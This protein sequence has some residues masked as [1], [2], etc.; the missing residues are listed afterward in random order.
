M[1]SARASVSTADSIPHR[2]EVEPATRAGQSVRYHANLPAEFNEIRPNQGSRCRT[3]SFRSPETTTSSFETSIHTEAARGGLS[4]RK[5]PK[6]SG[7]AGASHTPCVGTQGIKAK[8]SPDEITRVRIRHGL[9]VFAAV[10]S[11]EQLRQAVVKEGGRFQQ[12][13]C[14]LLRFLHEAIPQEPCGD[15]GVVVRPHQTVATARRS[16][17]LQALSARI[18][19]QEEHDHSDDQDDD[20]DPEQKLEGRDETTGE[21]QYDG[22]DGDNDE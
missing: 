11:T 20:S 10:E 9:R 21:E 12:P 3:R 8:Q 13:E 7:S 19:S 16:G 6:P 14:N 5:C 2:P 22:H 15:Q 4:I 18:R 1:T 17:Q